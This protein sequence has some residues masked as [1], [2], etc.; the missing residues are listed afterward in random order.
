M[1]SHEVNTTETIMSLEVLEMF[2]P[3]Y[4]KPGLFSE[5]LTLE[6]ILSEQQLSIDFIEV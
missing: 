6:G 2:I 1:Q 4:R 5:Q 3:E